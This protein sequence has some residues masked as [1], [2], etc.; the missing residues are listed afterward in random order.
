MKLVLLQLSSC[1][2]K[3][4]ASSCFQAL[5]ILQTLCF[6]PN[7][8]GLN[9]RLSIEVQAA[10][11]AFQRALKRF[12]G[13][14]LKYARFCVHISIFA[15]V[16]PRSGTPDA[17]WC[18]AQMTECV[19]LRVCFKLCEEQSMSTVSRRHVLYPRNTF[20]Q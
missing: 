8:G 9:E 6:V 17:R 18:L 15:N 14:C 7:K 20:N 1:L 11:S 19:C 3:A 4:G 16:L 5:G 10:P 2:K 12:H 13:W